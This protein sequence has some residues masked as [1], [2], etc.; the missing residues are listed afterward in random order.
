MTR[1]VISRVSCYRGGGAYN[2]FAIFIN[3]CAS[4]RGGGGGGGVKFMMGTCVS[5]IDVRD[6]RADYGGASRRRFGARGV[7]TL[8]CRGPPLAARISPPRDNSWQ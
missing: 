2:D 3:I 5:N 1:N 4:H 6:T 7:H 8:R